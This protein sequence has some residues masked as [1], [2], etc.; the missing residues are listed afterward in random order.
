[1]SATG[2]SLSNEA[3]RR[4]LEGTKGKHLHA[5]ACLADYSR[6]AES[7]RADP[8]PKTAMVGQCDLVALGMERKMGQSDD[9]NQPSIDLRRC[10]EQT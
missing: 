5:S 2:W 6:P 8:V 9:T 1:M 3:E 7:T 4:R 10:D